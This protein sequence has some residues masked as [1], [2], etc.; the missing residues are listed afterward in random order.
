[1]NP[2]LFDMSM[3][4]PLKTI[5]NTRVTRREPSSRRSPQGNAGPN[6]GA[7][8]PLTTHYETSVI[9]TGRHTLFSD[10]GAKLS[11]H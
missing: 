7:P 3:K 8:L 4:A 2:V 11:R 6:Q 5:T 1:M 10:S 9:L